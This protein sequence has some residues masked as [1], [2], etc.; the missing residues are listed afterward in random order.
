MEKPTQGGI[1][2][3]SEPKAKTI[4]SVEDVLIHRTILFRLIPNWQS[5]ISDHSWGVGRVL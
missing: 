4:G 3:V 2:L 5:K 1:V